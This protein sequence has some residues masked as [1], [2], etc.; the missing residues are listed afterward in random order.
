MEVL[1]EQFDEYRDCVRLVWNCFLRHRRKGGVSFPDVSEALLEALV[2][3]NLANASEFNT[4]RNVVALKQGA[5]GYVRGLGIRPSH[6]VSL[7]LK[8]DGEYTQDWEA[9]EFGSK[10]EDQIF[11]Y[12][13]VFD[14]RSG[15]DMLELG[16][17]KVVAPH[18][19]GP[20]NEGALMA[21]R[22]SEVDVIDLTSAS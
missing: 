16:Y 14:F 8:F 21:F 20:I 3:D 5:P 2:L 15:D 13:D 1:N 12:V 7:I 19:Y 22:R 4:K 6:G 9:C 11:Y 18:N 10:C 17:V